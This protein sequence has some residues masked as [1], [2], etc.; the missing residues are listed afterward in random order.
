MPDNESKN[1]EKLG[2]VL[3]VE[4]EESIRILVE[5]VL[6]RAGFEVITAQNGIEA[7]QKLREMAGTID[8]LLT[9]LVLP[10]MSGDICRFPARAS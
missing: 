3:V 2:R 7:E 6:T 9:D 1:E 10:G 8:L 4:D 5:T